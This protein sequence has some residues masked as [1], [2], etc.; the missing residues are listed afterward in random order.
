MRVRLRCVIVALFLLAGCG[1][2]AATSSVPVPPDEW[3]AMRNIDSCAILDQAALAKLGQ[4]KAPA[5][6][7]A[8]AHNCVATITAPDGTQIV[9]RAYVGER[10][11]A[12]AVPV[13]LG[14]VL[15]FQDAS[16][17][18]T[19]K[20]TGDTGI[21]ISIEG[22]DLEKQCAQA[23]DVATAVAP[24]LKTPPQNQAASPFH[25]KDPCQPI[26]QF[27][28]EIGALKQIRRP[29]IINCELAGA[30]G[31]LLISYEIVNMEGHAHGEPVTVAGK[32]AMRHQ[33]SDTLDRCEVMVMLKPVLT[34]SYFTIRF[35]VMS[36]SDPCAKATNA[37]NESARV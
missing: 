17:S 25:G 8:S 23:R 19:V 14:G 30:D 32:E 13:D 27:T 12:D 26:D 18:V 9:A 35:Q 5:F 24:K 4:V 11:V 6:T 3:A 31:S 10:V 34:N 15:A 21:S 20:I 36:G 1:T 37:A 33:E 29:T 28:K 7:G 2:D 22:D 16:C